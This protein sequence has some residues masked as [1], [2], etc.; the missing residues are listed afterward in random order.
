LNVAAVTTALIAAVLFGW[1]TALMHHSA[2]T[3]GKEFGSLYGLVRYLVVQWRWLL[4]MAASLSGLVVHVIALDLGSIAVVQPL[5]VTGL[6]FS[7]IFRA[8]LDRQLLPRAVLGWVLLTAVGL[9]L[10]LVTL[11]NTRSTQGPNGAAVV[12]VLAVGAV[13]AAVTFL[14]SSRQEP[15]RSGFLLGVSGGV[16]F[17]LIAGVLKS[18]TYNH[19]TGTA[20]WANWAVYAV[21]PLGVAG[22]LTNQRAYNVAP[23]TT[24]LPILNL[25]NPLV[26]IV[27]G[28][29][30]FEERPRGSAAENV[31]GVLGLLAV[32]VGIFFLARQPGGE[33]PEVAKGSGHTA[34]DLRDRAGEDRR[35]HELAHHVHAESRVAGAGTGG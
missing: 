19:G 27:F 24:S 5:V 31:L 32:L 17:G 22:F 3:A 2:S 6:V 14:L 18:A 21:I 23:L 28:V 15:S 9:T 10:F 26:A 29:V 7:F 4:G 1:S 8:A 20:F 34:D 35:E 33:T 12:G 16:I 25:L 13:V 11:G 30:A